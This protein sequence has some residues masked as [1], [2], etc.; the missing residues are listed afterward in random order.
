MTDKREGLFFDSAICTDG[1]PQRT[2]VEGNTRQIAPLVCS[3]V[4]KSLCQQCRKQWDGYCQEL[5]T[6]GSHSSIFA[7]LKS[8]ELV[9]EAWGRRHDTDAITI[10]LKRSQ[11]SRYSSG[12][13]K[14][15]SYCEAE[16]SSCYL[17]QFCFN[18]AYGKQ[19]TCLKAAESFLLSTASNA[20]VMDVWF[21]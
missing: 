20:K 6:E 8:W 4:A 16:T 9:A 13:M 10:T 2:P 18:A 21:W 3:S 15:R 17:A 7:R 5:Q 1:K 12:H 14:W 11:N 19:L